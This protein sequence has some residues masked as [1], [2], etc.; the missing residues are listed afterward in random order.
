MRAK[1]FQ[2]QRAHAFG[3]GVQ[4]RGQAQQDAARGA[5]QR[6]VAHGLGDEFRVGHDD[7][8]AVAQLDL[9]GAHVDAAHI[10]LGVAQHHPVAHFHGPLCQQ[11]QARDEVLH[12]GLQAEADAHRQRA[13]HPGNALH[14]D[15]QPR[16]RHGHHEDAAHIAQQ[17]GDGA[18]HARLQRG[19]GEV[20]VRQ[21]ALDHADHDQARDDH[22]ECGEQGLRRHGE[23]AHLEAVVHRAAAAEHLVRPRAQ[24]GQQGDHHVEQQ[25]HAQQARDQHRGLVQQPALDAQA[26]VQ[27]GAEA[28]LGR[29]QGLAQIVAQLEQQV[30]GG[31]D[32]AGPH[33]LARQR[34]GQRHVAGHG[35][36]N[37]GNAGHRRTGH[38]QAHPQRPGRRG[39]CLG[40]VFLRDRR[41]RA[42]MPQG[43]HDHGRNQQ[44]RQGVH[45]DLGGQAGA[46]DGVDLGHQAVERGSGGNPPGIGAEPL[47]QLVRH[48][49]QAPGTAPA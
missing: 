9:G 3:I 19:V 32:H 23:V 2:D 39:L 41:R 37:G 36:R 40:A 28:A 43:Q 31:K 26:L 17:R 29:Q 42:Q 47:G 33:H 46:D 15:A 35:Q 18:A 25:G 14:A 16:Q 11:D 30:G 5:S 34:S 21:P 1:G 8:G 10:A 12:D 24:R 13:G 7:G 48:A 38:E 27:P 44:G 4:R 6:H 22:R 45:R 49:G 20:A